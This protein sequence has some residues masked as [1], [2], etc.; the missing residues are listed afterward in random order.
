[1]KPETLQ[2]VRF[3]K[4]TR[5]FSK[6]K[7]SQIAMPFGGIGAGSISL[8]GHGS[9]QDFAVHN[10]PNLTATPD[11]HGHKFAAF[12][13]V[14]LKGTQPT[15]RLCEGPFPASRIYDQGLMSQGLRLGGFEGFPR[16]E[17]CVFSGEYPFG[18]V[19]LS[20]AK[21][22]LAL[23]ITGFSPFIPL[24]DLHS[25]MPCLFLEYEFQ[26]HSNRTVSFEFSFHSS[27]LHEPANRAELTLNTVIPGK[28]VFL[29][30]G[31]DVNA[32]SHG[33]NAL[34]VAGHKPK[35]K[36]MWFRGGWFD[37]MSALWREVSTGKFKANNGTDGVN[38]N[39]RNGGS[40]NVSV[41]LK[42]GQ[43]TV[44]PV[45]LA[46]HFPN[47]YSVN[48]GQPEPCCCPGGECK[49]QQPLWRPFYAAHWKD[50]RDVAEYALKHYAMLREKT[51][52]FHDALFS[53]TL[54]QPLLDAVSANLAI[55]KS[56]TILRQENGN[57]WAWEG[58]FPGS[59]C[60][61]GSCTH[62]WNYAQAMPHLFP[63][64][65]RTLREQEL[66]RSMDEKGHVTFRAALPDGPVNHDFHAAADGQLGGIMKIFRDWR[67]SGDEEWLKAMYPAA[68]QSMEF[69]V[70]H[71]DP[72]ERGA[73][74]EPHHNTYDIE[75]WG[76]DG[77]H[78]TIYCGALSAIAKMAAYLGK[79]ADFE[80]YAGLAE[81]AAKVLD[82]E[83]WNGEFYVQKV[84]FKGLQDNSFAEKHQAM[85]EPLG[86]MD[87]LLKKEGPKYQYG[88]GC[89]SD[90]VIGAWMAAIYGID[91]PLNQERIR[92]NLAAIYRHNF[93]RDLFDH[94]NCQRPGYA[95]GHEAG[96]LVCS[97]PNGG[98]PTLPFPYSDEVWTGMEY[99]VASHMIGQGLVKEGLEI[100]GAA[101]NRYDGIARNPWDEY[102]CGSFYARAMSSYALLPA[103]SGFRYSPVDGILHLEPRIS[104]RPFKVFFI[105]VAGYGTLLLENKRLTVE[106]ME[107]KLKLM[108]LKL[109]V[110]KNPVEKKL[111]TAVVSGKTVQI[112][113]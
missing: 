66:L 39:G 81:K 95:L 112:E 52:K 68:K 107:G 26:N 89:L 65:E 101:R 6:E 57:V 17:K 98:K 20:D 55:L 12:A 11:G 10:R 64:L 9:L 27:H 53:S 96:L 28:G 29:H 82:R 105:T 8:N 5:R 14:H 80:R 45:I 97:W 41:T 106:L 50:A 87:R 22:P 37:A 24:D 19:E 60:C 85:K 31:Q 40:I 110:G 51:V 91:T 59:G 42:P 79:S 70:R 3:L 1:M 30:D 78:T 103:Y 100:V 36:G 76:A 67:I 94:A 18:K 83:L 2:P 104:K 44:I 99:Q 4:S 47:V 90:G 61:A 93:K 21:S 72:K 69:A 63:K 113:L 56:P 54:P 75:F 49:P 16:F 25:S 58:C 13:M 108:G 111:N 74:E 84:N 33:S 77:M 86:E 35:I 62:V 73:I 34:V 102:E 46:W 109:K 71:W 32:E 92:K 38:A 23:T 15:T 43:S 88:K 48:H 7:L